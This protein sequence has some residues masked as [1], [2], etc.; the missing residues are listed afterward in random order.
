M[1]LYNT[2][3]FTK[4]R[5]QAKRYFYRTKTVQSFLVLRSLVRKW[6]SM[7]VRFE[8]QFSISWKRGYA[9]RNVS[10]FLILEQLKSLH[11]KYGRAQLFLLLGVKRDSLGQIRGS[12]WVKRQSNAP[13]RLIM[14]SCFNV[15]LL[16][17][18]LLLCL[19]FSLSS[20]SSL[21]ND[22]L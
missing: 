17:A 20:S 8:F 5:L 16:A 10:L 7:S 18:L 2:L 19:A 1:P 22:C 3:S 14:K 11:R 12:F 6:K 9:R 13:F 15:E 21:I 4:P